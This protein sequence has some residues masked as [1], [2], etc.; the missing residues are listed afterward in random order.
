MEVHT[1]KITNKKLQLFYFFKCYHFYI[2]LRQMVVL[3]DVRLALPNDTNK[4]KDSVALLNSTTTTF[5]ESNGEEVEVF[6]ITVITSAIYLIENI[7][8]TC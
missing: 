2:A 3:H 1:D 5:I 7:H 8:V 6:P 4:P